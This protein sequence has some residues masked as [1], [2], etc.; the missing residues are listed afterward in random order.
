MA[1][2]GRKKQVQT[3]TKGS[4]DIAVVVMLLVSVLLAVLIYTKS[5]FLGEHL[6][7]TLGGVMGAIKYIIPIGAFAIAIYLAYDKD[8]SLSSK[9]MQYI[10]FLICV[11]T[12]LSVFQ[13]SAG[14]INT[15]KDMKEISEQAYYLGA[16]DIGGGVVGTIVAVPLVKLLGTLGTIVLSIGVALIV[17]VILFSIKPTEIIYS[18]VNGALDRREER[19][20][21]RR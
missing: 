8:N 15:T 2:R 4:I 18:I 16:R 9:L 13:I 3:K 11:A 7:P 14:N 17:F 1:K 12:M 6:S 10:I 19:K 20:E 5:G 21:S